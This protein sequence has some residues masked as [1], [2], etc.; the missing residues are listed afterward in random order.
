MIEPSGA[1]L[2]RANA[3]GLGP[4][5]LLRWPARIPLN[6]APAGPRPEPDAAAGDPIELPDMVPQ[7]RRA[8]QR[9]T[10]GSLTGAALPP[11]SDDA[12]AAETG[13]VAA[14]G[15]PV[16]AESAAGRRGI[17]V[18]D[19]D[20]A[21]YAASRPEA[22]PLGRPGPPALAG[23]AIAGLLLVAA[24]LAMSAMQRPETLATVP[25][26][27][28]E[29]L[30]AD[31]PGPASS[32]MR[33]D[34]TGPGDGEAAGPG[35]DAAAQPDPGYVPEAI[36]QEGTGTTGDGAQNPG[37][38]E[39]SDGAQGGDAAAAG[40]GEG[41]AE[42][43]GTQSTPDADSGGD[44][45]QERPDGQGA[46]GEG[47]DGGSA[48]Q[49]GENAATTEG[50]DADGGRDGGETSG[51]SPA[52]GSGDDPAAPMV[53]GSSPSGDPSPDEQSGGEDAAGRESGPSPSAAPS[54][55]PSASSS[56]PAFTA[57]AGPGCPGSPNASYKTGGRDG[58]P[59]GWATRD[60]GYG[61][62]GCDGAYDAIPVSGTREYGDGRYA[63]WSFTPGYA[64]A[65]C[66]IF[67]YVPEDDSPQWVAG[68]EAMYQV[69]PG[70]DA[71][72]SAAAVFGVQQSRSK[73]GW[74]KVTGFV[75]AEKRFTVQLTNIGEDTVAGP[76]TSHV[77]ASAV[78]TS[79]S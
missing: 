21:P 10:F 68:Q 52:G 31:G 56:G 55:S 29:G 41:L 47:A 39:G 36:P 17:S 18:P 35:G 16:A 75:S 53:A 27:A 70:P 9:R 25:I 15:E 66:D 64:D 57:L 78:R 65:E 24:P 13:G 60:G 1:P 3:I 28:G 50:G 67:V 45:G 51:D 48:S 59:A 14:S 34:S 4:P 54:A 20:Q 40:S 19:A 23:A 38:G 79:C 32:A 73:G 63:A 74:V 69:F 33:Q 30:Q 72:G 43:R 22:R 62:D 58:N 44:D 6:R 76:A 49:G 7:R 2:S 77:A 71:A 42:G 5:G 37:Q 46:D 8:A 61:L 26:S 12:T 11:D